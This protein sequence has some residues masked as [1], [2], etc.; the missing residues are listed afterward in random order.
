MRTESD[1]EERL[2]QGLRD[3]ANTFDLAHPD[4]PPDPIAHSHQ[5]RSHR[6]AV[7]GVAAA[8]LALGG[9]FLGGVGR[10]PATHRAQAAKSPAQTSPSSRTP[11]PP[12]RPGIRIGGSEPAPNPPPCPAGLT[13]PTVID[14]QYCGPPPPAGNGLGPGGVCIGNET[15]TPCGP[16]VTVGQYYAYTVPGTCDGLIIFDGK[17]W[18]SELPPPYPVPDFHV[19]LGLSADGVLRFIGPLGQVSFTP[20][21]GQSLTQ[22]SA[23]GPPAMP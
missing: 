21:T 8:V 5:R 2:R 1:L 18:V 12:V 11:S 23:S 14:G 4:E 17:R 6:W 13:A 16:G 7:V 10:Q 19:W 9:V 15:T 20:Y 3:R 22:C